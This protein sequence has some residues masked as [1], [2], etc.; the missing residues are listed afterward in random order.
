MPDRFFRWVGC[1]DRRRPNA[2]ERA[3]EIKLRV[4]QLTD[5]HVP[6][7]I[8]LA[9]RLRD[10]VRPHRTVGNLSHELSAI[11]NE[12]SQPYRKQR[13]VYTNL[14]KKA[15]LGLRYLGVD[16]LIITGDVAHCGL[17]VEFLEAKA[18]LQVTG[19]WGADKL[20]VIPG[21]HDRFN[22]YEAI[23]D[24]PMESFFDV[25]R[26]RAPRVKV[27]PGGLA[28]VETDSNSDRD[29][30]R[31][32]AEHWLPNTRGRIYEEEVDKVAAA[33]DQMAGMRVLT[34]VHHHVTDDWYRHNTFQRLGF[35][36]PAEGGE[37]L[38][39]AVALTDPHALLLHGH[40]HDVMPLGYTY[41]DDHLVGCPGGFAEHLRVNLIDLDAH[42][43]ITITQA[44]LR[45][46]KG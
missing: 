16:H 40:I 2:L 24:E 23:P 10:L 38:M 21:N 34:L 31:G 19:W 8:T 36:D 6:S 12:L 33:L 7:D 27:L 20:T 22:L 39:A 17:A 14:L 45:G 28:L 35:L 4:A 42:D 15:L 26:S 37:E 29:D 13:K 5:L 44:E 11:S 46:A 41:L 18:A 3:P 30:D 32:Y 1:T 43:A 9:R 25:V